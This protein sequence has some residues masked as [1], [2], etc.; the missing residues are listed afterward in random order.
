VLSALAAVAAVAIFLLPIYDSLSQLWTWI[1]TLASHKG[2]YGSGETGFVSWSDVPDRLRLT[3]ITAP[4]VYFGLAA[5]ILGAALAIYNRRK[6]AERGVNALTLLFLAAPMPLVFC[7]QLLF[8]MKHFLRQYLVA[9]VPLSTVAIVWLLWLAHDRIKTARLRRYANGA[10]SI[11]LFAVGIWQSATVLGRIDTARLERDTDRRT[12][13]SII[14]EYP[15]SVVIG[16]YVVPEIN[17]AMHFGL[18][19]TRPAFANWANTFLPNDFA[20]AGDNLFRPGTGPDTGYFDIA[21]LNDFIAGGQHFLVLFPK[22]S[23]FSRLECSE[24]LI[25]LRNEHVCSLVKVLPREGGR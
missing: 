18:S 21:R 14:A 22:T 7:V 13:D 10:V 5:S 23:P 19:Y 9:I 20:I 12:L 2:H 15:G 8:V 25:V 16:T 11:M 17:Y 3:W 4:I 6:L 1:L 24:P